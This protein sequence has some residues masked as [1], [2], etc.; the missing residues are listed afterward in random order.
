[1]N[2]LIVLAEN[3]R[4]GVIVKR[5]NTFAEL[6]SYEPSLDKEVILV[7]GGDSLGDLKA[8]NFRYDSV[9][10]IADDNQNTIVTSGGARWRRVNLGY[11]S[12]TQGAKADSA[13]QPGANIS[14]LTNDSGLITAAGAPVQ[15]VNGATGAVV[16]TAQDI[17]AR[18]SISPIVGTT[19]TVTQIDDNQIL[20]FDTAS[21]V[22][23]TLPADSTESLTEATTV[24]FRNKQAG[25]ITVAVEGTDVLINGASPT[26]SQALNWVYLESKV[27]GV[28]TY[29]CVGS[30]A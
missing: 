29:V 21:A 10:V 20:L 3:Q 6:R 9:S 5:V 13:L 15:S 16:I 11:A 23:I 30:F 28:N 27:G 1:M 2:E 19:H 4:E 7:L 22:T 26:S 25:A 12:T 18:L 24:Y 8:G 14:S 17:G